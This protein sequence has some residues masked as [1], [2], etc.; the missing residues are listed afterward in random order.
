MGTYSNVMTDTCKSGIKS[1]KSKGS[2]CLK[3]DDNK[4]PILVKVAFS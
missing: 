4:M 2:N 3:I 1:V